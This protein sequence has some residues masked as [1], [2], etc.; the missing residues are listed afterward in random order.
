VSSRIARAIQRNPVSKNPP[1]K[2]KRKQE[3][4]RIIEIQ[5][6]EREQAKPRGR[7]TRRLG[8]KWS[9]WV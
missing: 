8:K 2:K 5:V 6:A 4:Q 9:K 3:R 1:K 7:R